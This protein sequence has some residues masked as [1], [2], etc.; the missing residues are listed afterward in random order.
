M[1]GAWK[2]EKQWS[3]PILPPR[4][5]RRARHVRVYS[6]TQER[7]MRKVA[8]KMNQELH[9]ELVRLGEEDTRVRVAILNH[10]PGATSPFPG[11]HHAS[12]AGLLR[13][14]GLPAEPCIEH[15]FLNG[16]ARGLTLYSHQGEPGCWGGRRRDDRETLRRVPLL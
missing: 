4:P 10:P 15:G 11:R 16:G 14:V 5:S 9:D 2:T 6:C 8:A 13:S 3:S 7:E 1:T 12:P